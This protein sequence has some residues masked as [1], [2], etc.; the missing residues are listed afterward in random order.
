MLTQNEKEI[1]RR[2]MR[3]VE[4]T[5]AQLDAIASDDEVARSAI[6]EYAPALKERLEHNLVMSNEELIVLQNRISA[7]EAEL[8]V[9]NFPSD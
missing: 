7:I 5:D 6:A 4:F 3:M 8:S 9:F 2:V 1:L